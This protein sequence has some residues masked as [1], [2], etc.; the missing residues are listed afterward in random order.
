M[1][2]PLYDL[3]SEP[4]Q[5]DR[6]LIL[7]LDGWIDAGGA[8]AQAMAALVASGD[9]EVVATFDSD[10]LTDSRARRPTLQLTD[11]VI[12]HLTWPTIELRAGTDRDGRG[13]LLLTGPEPDMRWKQFC[14]DVLA[15]AARLSATLTI[16]LGAFPSPVPHTRPVRLAS[17]AST[18]ELAE[19]VGF[20]PGTIQV[21]V[22][23]HAAI[24]AAMAAQD[25]PAVG[26]W[27]RVPHYIAN[28]PYPGAAVAL[29]EGVQR[30]TGI[31]VDL[32]ELQAAAAITHARVNSLISN[33]D[34]HAGLLSALEEQWDAE[35]SSP[36]AAPDAG[37]MPENLPSAD[38]L[39][40]ELEKFLRNQ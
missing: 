21:P 34:E 20:M 36:V 1:P 10:A 29:L 27:A 7:G 25:R 22:G 11:G 2:D 31:S 24:E 38:E 18:S 30:L 5:M 4:P 23:I 28:I 35:Y 9:T 8:A 16:G 37:P 3:V 15:L 17:T 13:L 32:A 12:E 26:V 39:A 40:A 33:S 14:D 19:S 6:V